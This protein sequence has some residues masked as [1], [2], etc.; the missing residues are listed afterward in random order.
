[1]TDNGD[2]TYSAI[3]TSST[4]AG[5][6][7][8]TGTIDGESVVDDATVTFTPGPASAANTTL[9]A[10]PLSITADGVT[11][12]TV[13]VQAIDANGNALTSG[14]DAIVLATTAGTLS[15]VTDNGDGTADF[16]NNR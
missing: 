13:T 6:A 10:A 5:N 15:N 3:L 11:T 12:S 1:M 9:T 14:G 7:T 16:V 8:V 4:T 2:G